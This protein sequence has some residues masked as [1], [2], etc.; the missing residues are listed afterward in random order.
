MRMMRGVMKVSNDRKS[1]MAQPP[2][3]S[4]R[5]RTT[6]PCAIRDDS[7]KLCGTTHGAEDVCDAWVPAWRGDDGGCVREMTGGGGIGM[8]RPAMPL[9]VRGWTG[10]V[11]VGSG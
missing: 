11:A 5:S 2:I 7:F 9:G 10:P 1:D 8:T 3:G 6:E 4:V